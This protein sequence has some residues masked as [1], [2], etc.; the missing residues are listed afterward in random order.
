MKK[1]RLSIVRFAPLLLILAFAAT[2]Y[3]LIFRHKS[4]YLSD[5]YF[6]KHIFYQMKGDSYDIARAKVVSQ[7]DLT[8]AD[9]ITVNFFTKDEAY[10]NSLSFFT[11]RPLYPLFAVFESLFVSDEFL[12]FAT[13]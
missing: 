8:G 5:S 13:P 6:Y 3:V 1:I 10:E 9:D 4:P 7:V 2:Q 11:K 12:N